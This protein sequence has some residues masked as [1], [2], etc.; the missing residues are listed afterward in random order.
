MSFEDSNEFPDYLGGDPAAF[1]EL[2]ARYQHS[3]F[4][5]LGRMGLEPAVCEEIAQETFLSAWTNRKRY[6]ANKAAVSTWLFTI[7]RNLALNHLSKKTVAICHESESVEKTDSAP[8]PSEQAE[9]DESIIRL[10]Q[11]LNTLSP[12]DREVIATCYT[13]EIDNTSDVL[14][15]KAGT[16]RTRLSRARQRLSAALSKLD[17]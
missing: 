8:D 10:R 13:P 3:L 9:L 17:K 1:G 5:F 11:A 14:G 2:V 4:G 16:L 6:D 12:D 7:A 15:C